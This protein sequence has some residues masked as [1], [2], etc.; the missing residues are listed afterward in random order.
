MHRASPVGGCHAT[1]PLLGL[2]RPP[3]NS[4][5]LGPG[6][7][8]VDLSLDSLT[9]GA[10]PASCC[11]SLAPTAKGPAQLVLQPG[12]V[13]AHRQASGCS[14]PPSQPAP[15][16]QQC[17]CGSAKAKEGSRWQGD[18]L[19]AGHTICRAGLKGNEDQTTQV[20]PFSAL[21]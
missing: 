11:C 9:A 12:L 10:Q 16:M 20:V 3:V 13:Q 5:Q 7:C 15:A 21:I 4:R 8:Q 14:F 19:A 2:D 17:V 18:W 1:P 6:R